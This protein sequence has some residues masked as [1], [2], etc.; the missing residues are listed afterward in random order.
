MPQP[1]L[2]KILPDE[3]ATLEF[4]AL[5]APYLKQGDIV[6]FTG[7]LGAGKTTFTRGILQGLGG[8]PDQVHSP[9]FS[10]VHHY[11][12]PKGEVIH[13]DFYRLPNNTGLEEMGGLE[14]F[15]SD[16]IF[17]IEWSER[18]KLFDS[19]ISNR[20]LGVDLQPNA[21]GRQVR[22]FGPWQIVD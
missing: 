18:L 20:L 5:L 15:E 11:H 13:C 17:L 8:N 3:A 2:T 7:G 21:E 14:F 4:A 16:S 19:G 6:N 9:T 1:V 22:L 10:L 12:S